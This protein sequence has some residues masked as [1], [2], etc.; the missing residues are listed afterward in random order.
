MQNSTTAAVRH[1]DQPS[2]TTWTFGTSWSMNGAP[3][4]LLA[5]LM[6]VLVAAALAAP[7]REHPATAVAD[8]AMTNAQQLVEVI[9]RHITG[10][11]ES[12]RVVEQL[13]G[14]VLTRV[15]VIDGFIARIPAS[16]VESLSHAPGVVSVTANGPVRLFS[17]KAEG[18][19][20]VGTSP[21]AFVRKLTGS[22][23]SDRRGY[24]GSGIGIA[25]VDTG[26]ADVAGLPKV[27]RGPSVGGGS[28]LDGWGHGTHLAG[29]IAGNDGVTSDP[30]PLM[31]V[32]GE[33]TVVSL[34]TA[35]D[36]GSTNMATVLSA[37]DWVSANKDSKNIRVVNLSLGVAPLDDYRYDVL[38]IAVE[39]LWQQGVVVV[40]A[41]G[42]NG[43]QA[44]SPL[45]S[46]AYDPYVIAV[47]AEDPKDTD[48]TSDDVVPPFSPRGSDARRVDVVA[49]GQSIVSLRAPGSNAENYPA[50]FVGDRYIKG[51]GTSQ[52]AAVVS[53]LV[54]DLLEQRPNL[55]PDQVKWLLKASAT[56]L[57][58]ADAEGQGAGLVN[59]KKALATGTP[60]NATQSWAPAGVVP[61]AAPS[62][63]GTPP[64]PAG[65]T[66]S[67]DYDPAQGPP[68]PMTVMCGWSGGQW[69]A[70]AASFAGGTW[71]GGTWTADGTWRGGTWT[72]GTWTGGTW[73]GGTWTGG[74]WTGGTWT[75]GTWTGGTWTGGTWTGG[76]WTGGSW[77]GSAWTGTTWS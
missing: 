47:G 42:N 32:A 64:P 62:G 35:A 52:A 60:S 46:P 24:D 3:A 36:D 17:Q 30:N 18:A 1:E 54:A 21:L 45:T 31:G 55:T 16:E 5:L 29:I 39:H 14:Q 7:A 38:A 68:S 11:T 33:A 25:L 61:T 49:P 40:V 59:L 6:A 50:A 57:S 67:C 56:S 34:K 22:T 28:S 71:T 8:R 75:G 77:T 58:G 76:T 43:E 10:S 51:T 15:G 23:V 70:D 19:A 48:T 41:A 13:G 44:G 9:V 72:G 65:S 26:V 27:V 63:P 4:R 2:G 20:I 69:S 66:D 12:E 37:L 74:T 73:T 53:G